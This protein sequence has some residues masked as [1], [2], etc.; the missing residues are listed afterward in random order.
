MSKKVLTSAA[1]ALALVLVS[2][3]AACGGGGG[4]TD[5]LEIT[6]NDLMRFSPQEVTVPAGAQV[7]IVFRNVGQMPKQAMGHN[8]VVLQQGTDT[9]AFARAAVRHAQ[10]EYVPPEMADQV[11]AATAV[12]GPG[13]EATL[14]FTAPSEPGDYPFVCTFPGHTEAGMVGVL[15]VR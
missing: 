15:R 1:G 4:A 7:T 13:E 14:T 9:L 5:R 10:A 11:I 2:S 3:L 8:L 12:L 6:G